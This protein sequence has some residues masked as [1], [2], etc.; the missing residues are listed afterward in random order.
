MDT[1]KD[2][3]ELEALYYNGTPPWTIWDGEPGRPMAH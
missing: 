2:K 3:V 1:F